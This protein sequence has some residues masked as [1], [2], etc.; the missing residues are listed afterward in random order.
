MRIDLRVSIAALFLIMWRYFVVVFG[1]L[2]N[3]DRKRPKNE[4]NL[5]IFEKHFQRIIIRIS[6][7]ELILL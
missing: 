5:T 2:V 7:Y 4:I 1:W 6:L 3:S